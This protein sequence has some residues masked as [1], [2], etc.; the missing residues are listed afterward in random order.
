MNESSHYSI[1]IEWSDEDQAHV[2]LLPEWADRYAMPVASGSTYGEAEARG[3]HAL[4]NYI[5]FALED[6]TIL[7]RPRLFASVERSRASRSRR[8]CQ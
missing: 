3:R 7:P 8:N 6:G 4:E 5:R 2:V 1:T